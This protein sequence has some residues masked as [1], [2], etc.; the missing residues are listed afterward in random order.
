MGGLTDRNRVATW[1]KNRLAFQCIRSKLLETPPQSPQGLSPLHL[2]KHLEAS[3]NSK[4]MGEVIFATSLQGFS[5]SAA[6]Q[7]S[8]RGKI[9]PEHAWRMR[10][11]QPWSKVGSRSKEILEN[12]TQSPTSA[13][14][15]DQTSGA[16]F[17]CLSGSSASLQHVF[18]PHWVLRGSPMLVAKDK[19]SFPSSN[20]P[21]S[22]THWAHFLPF[23]KQIW[24]ELSENVT[25]WIQRTE[26]KTSI[27]LKKKRETRGLQIRKDYT[28][29]SYK[30]FEADSVP[31][32]SFKPSRLEL[33]VAFECVGAVKA[34]FARVD[35]EAA[36]PRRK[37]SLG[38]WFA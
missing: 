9:S 25:I 2:S 27:K 20:I 18:K 28:P 24:K 1:E 23:K 30:G 36:R 19:T 31:V 29:V 33:V 15:E 21:I 7:N 10:R 14:F 37:N 5:K 38:W 16:A 3:H 26:S 13:L 35:G 12:E 8:R 17:G 22:C 11:L 4:H 6:V 34:T 32:V